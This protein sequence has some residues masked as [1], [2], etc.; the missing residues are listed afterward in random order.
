MESKIGIIR[1]LGSAYVS[2]NNK[3]AYCYINTLDT[4]NERGI[5]IRWHS[6]SLLHRRIFEDYFRHIIQSLVDHFV[7]SEASILINVIS[8][9]NSLCCAVNAVLL[10][11]VD[12]GIPLSQLF[13]ATSADEND[14]YVFVREDGIFR[15]V[16]YHSFFAAKREQIKDENLLLVYEKIMCTLKTKTELDY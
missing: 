9:E 16:F 4:P 13:F 14:C 5:E 1:S 3:D 8:A 12:A 11:L 7:V 6:N 15:P 10:A 2:N